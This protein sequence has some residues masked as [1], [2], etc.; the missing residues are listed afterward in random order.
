MLEIRN[1]SKTYKKSDKKAIDSITLTVEDGD[2]IDDSPVDG[3][4]T[5]ILR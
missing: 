3:G 4:S 5:T 1:I 2:T